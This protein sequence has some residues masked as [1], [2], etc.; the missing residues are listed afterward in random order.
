MLR[1]HLHGGRTRSLLILIAL[2]VAVAFG[3]R[4]AGA[5]AS[6]TSDIF[7]DVHSLQAGA[8]AGCA[9]FI[10][11]SGAFHILSHVVVDDTGGTHL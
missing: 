9:E 6:A 4:A 10:D 8:F 2:V 1:E 7:I 11:W 3:A 5:R